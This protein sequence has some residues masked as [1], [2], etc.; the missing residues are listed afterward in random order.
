VSCN[1]NQ[2]TIGGNMASFLANSQTRNPVTQHLTANYQL[3]M[4]Q[5]NISAIIAK[6]ELF[7]F[8]QIIS[9]SLISAPTSPRQQR[10]LAF[11]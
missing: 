9:I 1:E 8:G 7:N 4:Q 6:V 11:I 10:H 3:P 2:E 5:S